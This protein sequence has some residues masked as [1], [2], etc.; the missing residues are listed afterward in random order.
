MIR[1]KNSNYIATACGDDSIKIFVAEETAKNSYEKFLTL[2]S[3]HARAHND[4]VNC[5]SWHPK[6]DLLASCGDDGIIRIWALI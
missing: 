6:E 1:K 3:S 5:V 2:K 4:D